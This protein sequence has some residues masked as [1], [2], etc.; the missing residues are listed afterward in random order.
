M[1]S[2]SQ[3]G[4]QPSTSSRLGPADASLLIGPGT[5]I[6]GRSRSA[7][8]STVYIEPPVAPDSTTTSTSHSA[9]TM[10]LRA[11][12]CHGAARRPSG[13]SLSRVP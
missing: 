12:N 2:T 1:S 9:A 4:A 3:T 13:Y 7:A 8:A 6:T 11:G 5:A 10:R